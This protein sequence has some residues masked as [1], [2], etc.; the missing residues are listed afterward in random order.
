MA[1]IGK[2]REKSW[3]LVIV[4]GIAMLAFVLGDLGFSGGGGPQEDVYG[5]GTIN[6]EKIDENQYNIFL[7][8]ARNNI[9]QSKLQQNPT[10]QPTITEAD[11]E[12]AANQAWT[13]SIVLTLMEKEYAKLGLIVDDFELE[14]V[15]YGQNGY[16]PSSMSSQFRDSITGE[17]APDQLRMA[18]DQL[19]NANDAESVM[20]YNNVIDYVRQERLEQ[21]YNV[22]LSMGIHATTLEGKAE[23]DA[24]NTVKNVSYVYE[25]FTKVPLSEVEEPTE[26][27][28]QDYFNAHKKEAKYKQQAS[29]K[30]SYFT[31]PVM[32]SGE[33][34]FRALEFLEALKPRFAAAKNDSTFVMRF[35]EVKLYANDST[36]MAR[37]EGTMAQGATYPA[38]VEEEVKAAKKGDLIGP[39]IGRNGATLSKVI[40]FGSE[41]TATVRHILI[42]AS[43]PEE[44]TIAQNRADSLIRV[45]RANGNFEEMVVQFSEDQGS[46]NNGGKYEN[47]TQGVMVPEFNDFSF[48]RPIGAL[49]SVKTTFGIHIV[50]VLGRETTNYPIFANVVKGVEVTKVTQD[51]VNSVVSNFIY[52]LDEMFTGKEAKERA[53]IFE[54]FVFDNGYQVRSAVI[55]D[56]NPSV[57][58]FS[59]RAEGRLLSLAYSDGAKAGDISASPILDGNRLAVALLTDIVKDGEPRLDLVR[60][61]I[62]AEI[63]KEKQAQYLIDKM[64]SSTNVESLAI[65]LG[66]KLETEGLTF[67]ANNVAVGN[68]PKIVGTAFSGLLD[69]ETSVP[70]KGNNGVFVLRVDQTTIG[71][72][73]TDYSA[74]QQQI[75]SQ[76]L[77]SLQSQFQNALMKSADVIDNRK[78]RSHGIR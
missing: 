52:E 35:S 69:G 43:S 7:N 5:I 18:L 15:L 73:T 70:V 64:M 55:L 66:A 75:K 47:F 76:G 16:P 20:Q 27:E 26:A 41:K 56:E 31:V 68:E 67:S 65:E 30:I 46:V 44:F 42:N 22:L 34:T 45:I 8:N 59:S 11:M 57:T 77:N 25:R 6:D 58:G 3:L 61:S 29:R 72:E 2:I 1:V 19:R 33:D 38:S 53:E 39:Y 28:I 4:V 63:R 50:E 12:N 24:K 62:V 60:E 23:Y 13:T 32:A 36:A 74:E 37:P 40:G 78:L 21:K 17:F 10:M 49:G 54:N 48:D 51:Q 71:D 9:L 14:N